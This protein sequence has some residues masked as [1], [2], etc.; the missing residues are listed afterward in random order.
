MTTQL[1]RNGHA[2]DDSKIKDPTRHP[3]CHKIYHSALRLELLYLRCWTETFREWWHRTTHEEHKIPHSCHRTVAYGCAVSKTRT[4]EI[5]LKY[6]KKTSKKNLLRFPLELRRLETFWLGNLD[7]VDTSS[8]DSNRAVLDWCKEIL[9][10]IYHKTFFLRQFCSFYSNSI[11]QDLFSDLTSSIK[12][13]KYFS[14]GMSYN[15]WQM[16]KILRN[17]NVTYDSSP[18]E[19]PL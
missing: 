7:P 10:N 3:Q 13:Y 19:T 2:N 16:Y 17:W 9:V 5:F 11:F 12:N 4:C 15:L 18:L 8:I 1:N 6:T 14:S